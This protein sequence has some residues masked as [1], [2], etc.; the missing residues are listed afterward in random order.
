MI[1]DLSLSRKPGSVQYDTMMCKGDNFASFGEIG[2]PA[3]TMKHP[4]EAAEVASRKSMI[5]GTNAIVVK[6]GS[7]SKLI[8][9]VFGDFLRWAVLR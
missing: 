2:S 3:R 1:Q 8:R 4:F 7:K 6:E 5:H 9:F